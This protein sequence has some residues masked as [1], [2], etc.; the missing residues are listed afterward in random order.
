MV[1]KKGKQVKV[2]KVTD[3]SVQGEGTRLGITYRLKDG[4]VI[5]CIKLGWVLKGKTQRISFF[6]HP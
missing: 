6:I 5:Y 1:T 4:K 2:E 3:K